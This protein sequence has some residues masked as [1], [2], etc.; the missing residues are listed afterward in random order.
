MVIAPLSFMSIST[1]VPHLWQVLTIDCKG[2]DQKFGIE[3]TLWPDFDQCLGQADN[4][5]IGMAVS[6]KCFL[7]L[8]NYRGL[9]CYSV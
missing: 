1:V 3:K 7:K 9:K 5:Q 2:F 4:P 6:N 8:R